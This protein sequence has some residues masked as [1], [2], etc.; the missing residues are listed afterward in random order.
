MGTKLQKIAISPTLLVNTRFP[1]IIAHAKSM[2]ISYIP[3]QTISFNYMIYIRRTCSYI[4][5]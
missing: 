1:S 2:S 5:N 4:N 3:Y